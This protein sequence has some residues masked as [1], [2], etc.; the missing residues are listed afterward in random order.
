MTKHGYNLLAAIS[1]IGAVVLAALD[2]DLATVASLI[3]LAGTLAGRGT[4]NA[5]AS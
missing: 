3:G 5:D 1:V 2:K 4:K